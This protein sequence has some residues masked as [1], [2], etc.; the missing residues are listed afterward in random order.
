MQHFGAACSTSRL[1]P[2]PRASALFQSPP[3]QHSPSLTIRVALSVAGN[4]ERLQY[5]I[6]SYGNLCGSVNDWNGTAGPDLRNA[7][8]LYYLNPLQ[9][10]NPS[11]IYTAQSICVSSCPTNTSLCSISNVPS[12]NCTQYRCA[13]QPPGALPSGATACQPPVH[14]CTADC[15][16]LQ[17]PLLP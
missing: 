8:K 15:V 11:T 4:P 10:L 13:P 12:L 7:T 6:D 2:L 5:G 9:L 17:V 1:R 14:R 16:L 3:T